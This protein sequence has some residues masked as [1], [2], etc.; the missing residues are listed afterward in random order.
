MAY[1]LANSKRIIWDPNKYMNIWI[2]KFTMSTSNTGTTTSYRMLAPTVMHSD[3]E[4]TSIPGITMKHKDAFNLSDVTNCLE[5]GFMLNLNALL[6]PTTVQG[7]NEFSLA[8][9]IAEY[10]GVL[11]T[12]CD[13]YSYLSADGDSDY[14]P[15]TY[16]FDYGYYPT[17]FKE[18][19]WMVS[20]RMIRPVRW[21]ISRLSTCWI[22]IVTNSLSIDQVKEG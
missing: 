21:N 19:I 5:V 10:L 8:T 14:C 4:L 1:I 16:S 11:Q 22:C 7:K 20:R 13:K 15:D 6:S 3:Y 2:A 12:R 18:T 9:P 17:V